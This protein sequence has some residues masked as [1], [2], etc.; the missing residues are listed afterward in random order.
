M[1][2]EYDARRLI[3]RVVN[4]G[5]WLHDSGFS[6]QLAQLTAGVLA[7]TGSALTRHFAFKKKAKKRTAPLKMTSKRE[8]D[9]IKLP[10][11]PY[12]AHFGAAV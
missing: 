6:Y 5:L 9:L 4:L 10:F 8:L 11:K 12:I 2:K 1:T 3:S 7:K